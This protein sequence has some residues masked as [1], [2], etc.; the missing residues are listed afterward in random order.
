MIKL[1]AFDLD[2]T[3]GDTL[4]L[5]I[6]AFGDAVSPYL[7]HKLSEEEI[8]RHFGL[9]AEGMIKKVAGKHWQEALKDYYILYRKLHVL[10]PEPFD[11]IKD[12]IT[13]LRQQNIIVALVT[14]KGERTC[15]ITLE[16]FEMLDCFDSIA[17]G[18]PDKNIKTEELLSLKNRYGLPSNQIVYVGDAVSD[19][20]SCNQAD[21]MC[22]SAGWAKSADIKQLE[23][24]N[25]GYVFSTI[26]SLK[27]YILQ[28]EASI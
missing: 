26:Q 21:V 25:K 23:E 12:W 15:Q 6:T 22:L 9:S 1:I 14:G 11:G 3:I 2:G 20:I 19:I 10:C 24:Y 7:D 27:E 4:P 28:F 16:Q 18:S 8:V 13:E 5:C 17:T